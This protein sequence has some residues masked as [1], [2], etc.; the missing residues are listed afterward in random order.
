ML[1]FNIKLFVHSPP[2]MAHLSLS[3]DRDRRPCTQP[4]IEWL[5]ADHLE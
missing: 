5:V 2:P 4:V 1:K 3:V